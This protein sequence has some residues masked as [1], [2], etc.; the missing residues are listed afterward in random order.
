MSE[1]GTETKILFLPQHWSQ[2]FEHTILVCIEFSLSG[3]Y[4]A[5]VICIRA[6][7]RLRCHQASRYPV[8]FAEMMRLPI[9]HP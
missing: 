7:V 2:Q 3:R 8:D 6:S 4:A 5:R 9:G 1:V